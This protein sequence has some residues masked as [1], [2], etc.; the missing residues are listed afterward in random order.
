[1]EI[2]LFK[3]K[4]HEKLNHNWKKKNRNSFVA[5]KKLVV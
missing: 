1:M 2:F 3:K 4:K 5:E